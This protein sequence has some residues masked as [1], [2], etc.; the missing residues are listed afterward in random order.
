MKDAWGAAALQRRAR[1]TPSGDIPMG[2]ASGGTGFILTVLAVLLVLEGIPYF[3]FPGAVKR[4]ALSIQDMPDGRLRL[5]G[6]VIIA[7]G[8]LILLSLRYA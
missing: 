4:W 2:G 5:M 6:L 8:L 3:G 1:Q 7:A